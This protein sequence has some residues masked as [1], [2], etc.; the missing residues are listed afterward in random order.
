MTFRIRDEP[1]TAPLA[2]GEYRAPPQDAEA[3]HLVLTRLGRLPVS[4]QQLVWRTSEPGAANRGL[5]TRS[6]TVNLVQ[7]VSRCCPIQNCNNHTPRNNRTLRS[8]RIHIRR[9]NNH[10]LRSS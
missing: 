7:Y 2:G 5:S 3:E 10:I 1:L 6:Q 8:N 4:R 9:R